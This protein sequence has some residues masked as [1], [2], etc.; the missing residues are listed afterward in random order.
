[1]RKLPQSSDCFEF[2]PF[3]PVILRKKHCISHR[4]NPHFLGRGFSLEHDGHGLEVFCG[5][6]HHLLRFLLATVIAFDDQD[7]LP[8]PHRK[9]TFDGVQHN[10]V[11]RKTL[12]R[13]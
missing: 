2:S 11:G 13:L 7:V 8:S 10:P 5:I 1:M 4:T 12:V 6:F 3:L 9:F